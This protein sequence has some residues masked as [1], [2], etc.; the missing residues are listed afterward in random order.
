MAIS[1]RKRRHAAKR[2]SEAGRPPCVKHCGA[3]ARLWA[4]VGDASATA[5]SAG[6]RS[7]A[8]RSCERRDQHG[9][10]PSRQ[11][12]SRT[13]WCGDE[14]GRKGNMPH[15]ASTKPS[16]KGDR[17]PVALG[18][19]KVHKS[20]QRGGG[21][22]QRGSTSAQETGETRVAVSIGATKE[23]EEKPYRVDAG[24]NAARKRARGTMAQLHNKT[25]RLR[26]H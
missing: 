26:T 5:A 7:P 1:S 14:T 10:P 25:Q 19:D 18:V 12:L 6:E 22:T 8:V 13:P 17:S 20:A 3:G 2:G 4:Q 24:P 23:P 11:G 9:T 16:E 21:K 15:W